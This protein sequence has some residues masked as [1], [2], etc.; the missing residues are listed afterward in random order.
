MPRFLSAGYFL[1]QG[2]ASQGYR[3][4]LPAGMIYSVSECVCA[5][6]PGS[7][8]L[9]W[10]QDNERAAAVQAKFAISAGDFR[11]LQCWVSARMAE[12]HF[13][14][15]NVFSD[16]VSAR[17]FFQRFLRRAPHDIKLLGLQLAE[18]Q[19]VDFFNT[20]LHAPTDALL[21]V[22]N[23][24][25]HHAAPARG[26]RVLGADVLAY[27]MDGSLHSF[28]CEGLEKTFRARFA[29]PLTNCALLPTWE[30]AAIAAGYANTR[31]RDDHSIHWFPWA[32]EEYP[33]G[34]EENPPTSN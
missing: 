4:T 32:V 14:W 21:G 27:E 7:W 25:K 9:P 26:G 11:E 6:L 2:R 31:F 20:Q 19:L 1:V 3:K 24:L 17:D 15:P 34:I 13:G 12:G 23:V 18:Y 28:L 10:V 16:P 30:Q 5:V 29:M 22:I 33:L 8:A